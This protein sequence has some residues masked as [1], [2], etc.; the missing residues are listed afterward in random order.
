MLAPAHDHP[1]SA[2]TLRAW[3][4]EAGLI[5]IEVE[6]LGFIVGRGRLTGEHVRLAVVKS[7]RGRP[8]WGLPVVPA[9]LAALNSRP[10]PK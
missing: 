10:I 5:D 8:E 2:A 3:F 6:R 4:A 1:Q 7:H 9:A